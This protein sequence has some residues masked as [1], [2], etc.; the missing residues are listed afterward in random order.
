MTQQMD[1]FAAQRTPDGWK[2][3]RVSEGG[4]WQVHLLDE[5]GNRLRSF[6][7]RSSLPDFARFNQPSTAGAHWCAQMLGYFTAGQRHFVVRAWWGA[8]LVIAL[9]RLCTIN[10][11]P[12]S[13]ELHSTECDI[14]LQGL[15][16]LV[17]ETENG[18]GPEPAGPS[19]DVTHCWVDTLV[20]FPGL[21]GLVEAVPLLRVLEERLVGSGEC[22][23]SFCYARHRAR[24]L[25]QISLRRLGQ[26]PRCYPALTFTDSEKRLQLRQPQPE[27]I[28]GPTR[29]ASLARLRKLAPL[30]AVYQL[31]GAPDYIGHA[32]FWRYDIDRDPP[33]TVLLYLG[34]DDTVM[35]IVRYLPAFWT[36]LELFPNREHSPFDADGD[37]WVNDG[38]FVGMRIEVDLMQEIASSGR[39]PLAPLAQAILDGDPDPLGPLADA[40]EEAGDPRAAGVRAALAT[41]RR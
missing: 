27:P 41:R 10:P 18:A 34:E 3:A 9:D 23:S 15:R 7:L 40:L 22:W 32:N 33:Y 25:A 16:Q 11:E 4:C 35:R 26:A 29:H 20:H 21:L 37:V 28:D 1:D 39:Y 31:L 17:T 36:D 13:N 8:R 30:A 6:D 24:R 19:T 2:M 14:V 5:Q 12:L 38:T